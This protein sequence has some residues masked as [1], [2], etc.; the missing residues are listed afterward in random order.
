MYNCVQGLGFSLEKFGRARLALCVGFN[1]PDKYLWSCMLDWLT[2]LL[3]L[4]LLLTFLR[5]DSCAASLGFLGFPGSAISTL[6]RLTE[7]LL[8]EQETE[9]S[10]SSSRSSSK[11]DPFRVAFTSLTVAYL[12]R[13][14]FAFAPKVALNAAFL[15][16]PPKGRESRVGLTYSFFSSSTSTSLSL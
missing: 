8:S 13:A 16:C 14:G 12:Y 5:V 6:P 7:S 9:S 3:I 2:F 10:V 4:F 11:S 15:I 1:G